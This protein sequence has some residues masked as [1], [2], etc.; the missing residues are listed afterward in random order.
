MN[1]KMIIENIMINYGKYGITEN[2]INELIDAGLE[3]GANY[4]LI[5]LDL[6]KRIS[7]ITQ[8]EFV[9]TSEDMARAYNVP[10]ETI[11]EMIQEGREEL[12]A[13]GENPDEYFKEVPVNRFMM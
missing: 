1:R 12:I 13:A 2:M 8:E 11:Y 5:Y 10:V 4:D 3:S 7:E 9:C 6:M